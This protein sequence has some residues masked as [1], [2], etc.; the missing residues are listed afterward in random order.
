M[1]VA[2]L[3]RSVL[4][5]GKEYFEKCPLCGKIFTFR[6]GGGWNTCDACDFFGDEENLKEALAGRDTRSSLMRSMDTPEGLIDLGEYVRENVTTTKIPTG[7]SVIDQTINGLICGWVTVVTGS[8]GQGKTTLVSQIAL[9]AVE[10]GYKVC[11]YS[12]ETTTNEYYDGIYRQAAGPNGVQAEMNSIGNNEYRPSY[13]TEQRIREWMKGKFFLSDNKRV[14]SNEQKV[15]F[16]RFLRA[17]HLKN[18]KLFIIDNLMSARMDSQNEKDFYR[19]QSA[20]VGHTV[21]FAL[22]NDVHV[23]LVAHPR[24]GEVLNPTDCMAGS[25]DIGNLASNVLRIDLATEKEK[26]QRGNIDSVLSISKN[27]YNGMKIKTGFYYDHPSKRLTAA[28]G[29]TITDYSWMKNDTL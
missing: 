8:T 19:Q 26:L 18:C 7:I 13:F 3:G 27:R 9:N 5:D 4:V 16:Q 1:E 29:R 6:R 11:A 23:I 12:G 22:E 20:F 24:K 14:G 28:E 2:D 10:A 17:R 21:Q 25:A 15:I